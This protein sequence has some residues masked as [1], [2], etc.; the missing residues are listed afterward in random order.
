MEVSL[1]K[2]NRGKVK[3]LMRHA[4]SKLDPVKVDIGTASKYD[5]ILIPGEKKDGQDIFPLIVSVSDLAEWV[6]S[7]VYRRKA[8]RTVKL[9]R[10]EGFCFEVRPPRSET[11]IPKSIFPDI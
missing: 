6:Q 5:I 9:R 2:A 7:G 1:Q 3:N 8:C 10:Q 11:E 4:R